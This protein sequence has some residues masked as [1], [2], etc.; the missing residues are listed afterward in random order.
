MT[1][2]PRI[3]KNIFLE[4]DGYCAKCGQ[5]HYSEAFG[6]IYRYQT[7][8]N[9]SILPQ[10]VITSKNPVVQPET[11][12]EDDVKDY[13]LQGVWDERLKRVTKVTVTITNTVPGSKMTSTKVLKSGHVESADSVDYWMLQKGQ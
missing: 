7:S 11:V 8:L 12:L 6:K 1:T 10:P 4:D 13:Q 3:C 5:N 9:V 2:T